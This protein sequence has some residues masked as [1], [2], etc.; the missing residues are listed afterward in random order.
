VSLVQLNKMSENAI[1]I[2][3]FNIA[4][5]QTHLWCSIGRNLLKAH[6]V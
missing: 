2:M 5:L 3:K 1:E 6:C 4:I